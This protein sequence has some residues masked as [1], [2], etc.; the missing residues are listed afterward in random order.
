MQGVNSIFIVS[1]FSMRLIA[2][3]FFLLSTRASSQDCN[4]KKTTDPYTKEV[5]LSTGFIQL[6]G[7]S[8]SID[9]DNKE[10]DFFFSMDGKE[11][12]F[13]DA[14]TVVVFYEGT[15]LKANFKNGGPM[16]CEGF[17]HIIFKNIA[18]TPALLQRLISQKITSIVFTGNNKVQTKI[19]LTAEEQQALMSRADCLVKQAKTLL[20]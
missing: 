11:K 19:T 13:S 14:S 20:K 18:A 5:K 7:V 12:C 9:A 8:L 3:I 6:D 1:T 4:V 2:V 16:N 17:F 15:K 10:V